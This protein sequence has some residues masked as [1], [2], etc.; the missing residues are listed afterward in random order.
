MGAIGPTLGLPPI[1]QLGFVVPDLHEAL[2]LYEPLFG[3]FT[4]MDSR[5]QGALLH[6]KPEDCENS[7]AFGRSGKLEIEIIAPRSG[8][9]PQQEFLD[10][11]GVGMHHVGFLVD[12]HDKR[13]RQAYTLDYVTLW[14][15][16]VDDI[17][18]SYLQRDGDPLVIEFL[19][20]PA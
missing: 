4:F 18:W 16:R 9:S 6:G 15:H 1:H 14:S 12:D 2:T 20:M 5:V 3:P 11:G 19:Q 8:R 13:V 7:L 10:S 17:A